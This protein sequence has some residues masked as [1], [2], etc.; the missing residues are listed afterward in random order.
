MTRPT[1]PRGEQRR[2]ALVAAARKLF[3]EKRNKGLLVNDIPGG[4]CTVPVAGMWL[5]DGRSPLRRHVAGDT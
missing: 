1:T 3:S 4:G 2:A 5:L